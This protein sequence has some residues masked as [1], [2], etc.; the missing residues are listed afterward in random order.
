MFTEVFLW[1]STWPKSQQT[2]EGPTRILPDVTGTFH[3]LLLAYDI[4]GNISTTNIS[5]LYRARFSL[6][7]FSGKKKKK[8][9]KNSIGVTEYQA[10]RYQFFSNFALMYSISFCI[11]PTVLPFSS[12]EAVLCSCVCKLCTLISV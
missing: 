11:C 12:S 1:R 10:L 5:L 2:Q 9:K 4:S 6:S 3:S 8:H 7:L